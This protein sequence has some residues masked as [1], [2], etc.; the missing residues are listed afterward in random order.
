MI[1]MSDLDRR[2]SILEGRLAATEAALS[3]ALRMVGRAHA[4]S[5]W[6]GPASKEFRSH[7]EALAD[8]GVF[9][10]PPAP[11]ARQAFSDGLSAVTVMSAN[12][13]TVPPGSQESS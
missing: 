5:S 10:I 1:S 7:I 4:A 11:A 13:V 8:R 2:I 6:D 12:G 9:S 3:Y